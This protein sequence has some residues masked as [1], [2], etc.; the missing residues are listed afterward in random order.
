MVVSLISETPAENHER[1]IPETLLLDRIR[2][3]WAQTEFNSLVDRIAVLIHANA[4][5][6]SCCPSSGEEVRAALSVLSAVLVKDTRLELDL[7]EEAIRGAL[8][9]SGLPNHDGITAMMKRGFVKDDPVR[10]LMWVSILRFVFYVFS[11][12][13]IAR[14]APVASARLWSSV[15][16]LR[17]PGSMLHSRSSFGIR[18]AAVLSFLV[19]RR[20]LLRSSISQALISKSFR[21]STIV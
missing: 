10:K 4:Y 14:A 5:V 6:S 9:G 20:W 1:T 18:A 12:D 11:S 8:S 7:E 19:L 21:R 3:A 16:Q 13:S 17:I 15:L 2:L